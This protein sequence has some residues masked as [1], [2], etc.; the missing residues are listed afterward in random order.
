MHCMLTHARWWDYFSLTTSLPHPTSV[1]RILPGRLWHTSGSLFN[2]GWWLI[3][4]LFTWKMRGEGWG[5][6]KKSFHV[7]FSFHRLVG[8][9]L[10]QSAPVKHPKLI[11]PPENKNKTRHVFLLLHPLS[12]S[13]TGSLV[14]IIKNGLV[15]TRRNYLAWKETPSDIG[16]RRSCYVCHSTSSAKYFIKCL[17]KP[18]MKQ[19]PVPCRDD[20][21]K[22][23]KMRKKTRQSDDDPAQ[24]HH[25]V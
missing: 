12:Q 21:D 25:F 16:R 10:E 20:G 22:R 8:T 4:N 6:R 13:L 15:P 24:L 1:Y 9:G 14:R 11:P 5:W 18:K 3:N 19:N 17:E 7:P 23:R 2:P